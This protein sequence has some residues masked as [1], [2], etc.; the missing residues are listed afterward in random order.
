MENG[1]DWLA[2]DK[3][4]HFLFCFFIVV[5]VSQMAKFSRNPLVRR[6][7]IWLGSLLSLVAGAAKEIGDE[8]GY[9]HSAGG[10]LK[11]GVADIAGVLLAS[12]SLFLLESMRKPMGLGQNQG[13]L[14][15]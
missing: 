14:M 11:D 3:A 2:L 7:G 9:W 5:F 1:D 4:Y 10:S 13:V 12:S 8:M 15:V 6:R